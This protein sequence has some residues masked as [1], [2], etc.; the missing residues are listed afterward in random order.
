[1]GLLEAAI[2]VLA[3]TLARNDVTTCVQSH[4]DQPQV[5][6]TQS[7]APQFTGHA[8]DVV[9]TAR[10][11]LVWDVTSN[12]ILYEKQADALRPVASL[13]K[14]VSVL[15]VQELLPLTTTVEI[16]SEARR[17][18]LL[19]ANIKLPIGQHATVSDL[20][21]ASL[22]ASANDAMVTLA[23]AATGSEA[24]FVEEAN[25]YALATGLTNT[26][27]ANATGL[28]QPADG[29]LVTQHSTA[30]DIMRALQ[31]VYADT[32]LAPHLSAGR[33][34]LQTQEGVVRSYTTTNQLLG[35]Y[36]PILAA[37]T[38]YTLEAGQNL[39]IIT[40]D[41]AGHEIGA[42]VL[43]SDQRFQDMKILIEWILR[44]YTWLQTP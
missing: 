3:C 22:I 43:G 12:T 7:F 41:T 36:L 25:R 4:I 18:Q 34:T 32:D 14:L 19:G 30:R 6:G 33:G 16:P 15:T 39:A 27:L 35:T 44:N 23:V 1:M 11:A 42:I 20:L 40:Q 9:L 37:K 31:R 5:A 24:A 10:A 28:S 13:S 38:G 2:L 8:L 17:A 21:A 29:V 26:Q